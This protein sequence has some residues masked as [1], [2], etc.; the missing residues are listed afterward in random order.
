MQNSA[1]LLAQLNKLPSPSLVDP[2]AS[3][4]TTSEGSYPNPFAEVR[5]Q[6]YY[7]ANYLIEE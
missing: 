4:T 2:H 3:A 1:D 5:L 6:L 7:R